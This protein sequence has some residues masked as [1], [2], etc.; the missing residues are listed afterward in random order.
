MTQRKQ[1]L[2]Q[3]GCK[4]FCSAQLWFL[5]KLE[6]FQ[7]NLLEKVFTLTPENLL[8]YHTCCY[9]AEESFNAVSGV[10]IEIK[11]NKEHELGCR[12]KY[13]SEMIKSE[14][15]LEERQ[16]RTS[17]VLQDMSSALNKFAAPSL[18]GMFAWSSATDLFNVSIGGIFAREFNAAMRQIKALTPAEFTPQNSASSS[19]SSSIPSTS[20]IV[21]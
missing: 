11:M 18:M 17:S 6:D 5:Y 4:H 14:H 13:L 1:F 12:L 3:L 20:A 10:E 16:A 8:Y 15:S 7:F 21:C 9:F 19:S 2:A